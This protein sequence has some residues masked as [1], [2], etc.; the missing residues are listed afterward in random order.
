M[1]L[2]LLVPAIS[3]QVYYKPPLPIP[4]PKSPVSLKCCFW[5]TEMFTLLN[6]AVRVLLKYFISHCNVSNTLWHM[7]MWHIQGNFQAWTPNSI[8][9]SSSSLDIFT[10]SVSP[11]EMIPRWPRCTQSP[12]GSVLQ[13]LVL[14]QWEPD[15]GTHRALP[16]SEHH[17]Q[18]DPSSPACA[19]QGGASSSPHRE[20]SY[21]TH[22]AGTQNLCPHCQSLPQ[23][24]TPLTLSPSLVWILSDS[25]KQKRIPT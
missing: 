9:T 17:L 20:L 7:W 23:S 11:W 16:M 24:L 10:G 22:K 15:L 12:I 14:G 1:S 8:L 2:K 13:A 5:P 25:Q 6:V 21:S 3:Q 18:I 4:K 19:P